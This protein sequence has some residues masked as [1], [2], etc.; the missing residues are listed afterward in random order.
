M[1]EKTRKSLSKLGWAQYRLI[2]NPDIQFDEYT[3]KIIST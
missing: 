2:N 1:N 3:E